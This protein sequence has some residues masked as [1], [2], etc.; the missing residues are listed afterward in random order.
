MLPQHLRADEHEDEGQ[1]DVQVDEAL[2]RSGEQE[3]E[4]AQAQHRADIGGVDD[5]RVTR[6]AEDGRDGIQREDQVGELHHEQDQ[7]AQREAHLSL[8]A[9]QEAPRVRA[10]GH[11][12][13]APRHRTT[14]IFSTSPPGLW[15]SM[16]TP[17]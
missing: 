12:Q 4:R 17:V 1:P 11:R 2:H 8:L 6:D 7:E 9:H 5:E 15:K 14:H 3:V 13:E 10:H 16:V